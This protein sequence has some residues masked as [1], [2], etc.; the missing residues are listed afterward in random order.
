MGA[1]DNKASDKIDFMQTRYEEMAAFMA[2]AHAKFTDEVGVC[3]ATF[4]T[5]AIHLLEW[6]DDAN[7]F[8]CRE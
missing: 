5:G 6:R 4:G 1:M 8:S 2:C 7:W 3:M